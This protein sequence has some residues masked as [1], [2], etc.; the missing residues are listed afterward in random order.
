MRSLPVIAS[1]LLL[2]FTGCASVSVRN[3]QR[4]K[5]PVQKPAVFYVADFETDDAAWNVTS[6]SKSEPQFQRDAQNL[7]AEALVA[8]LN[9]Y[10][11]PAQR[12]GRSSDVPAGGWLVTGRFIRVSEGNPGLRIVVGLGAGGSKMETETLVYSQ[13]RS[14]FLRFGTS[15]GSNAMPG[16]IISSGPVGAVSNVVQQVN[17]GV[18]DDAKRT[19]R[20]ITGSIGEYMAERGWIDNARLKA[21]RDG[22]FQILQPQGTPNRNL[23]R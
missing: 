1:A 18:R 17:R 16:M 20:M 12:V 3:V 8:N 4:G 14:P 22:Q 9:S 11:G 2:F 5:A 19:A 23:R 13:P 6:R 10:L 7:L 15:G 21:K